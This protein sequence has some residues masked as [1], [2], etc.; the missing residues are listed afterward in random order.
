[1]KI[2][3]IIPAY[4]E[5]NYIQNTLTSVLDQD[6]TDYEVIVVDNASTDR[7]V[8]LIV[9]FP[10]KL[11]TETRKGTMWACEAGRNVA[12]GEIIVRMDA[13][14][15]PDKD[16]LSRGVAYFNNPKIVAV[17]GPYDY[18][19]AP[20]FFRNFSL[21]SQKYI[22][23]Y[24]NIWLQAFGLGGVLIGGNT[25]MRS[26]SLKEMGGFNTAVTFYGDDTDTAKRISKYGRI[27]FDPN[28]TMKTSARRF[29]TE[30]SINLTIKYL[31]HF[32]KTI[33]K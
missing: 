5:E 22:Y 21:F 7:T 28:L 10:V 2:S 32:F 15:L 4:N 6:Y 20:T 26:K 1:M 3:V 27:Y 33:L 19:D 30:G 9:G 17:T 25:F 14:C 16:W 24:C 31:F 18:H 8:K 29:K 13:D 12:T 23:R 11:I